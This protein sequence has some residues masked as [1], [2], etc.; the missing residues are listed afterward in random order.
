[1]P[2][3]A[4]PAASISAPKATAPRPHHDGVVPPS[5]VA[6]A[7]TGIDVPEGT[8]VVVVDFACAAGVDLLLDDEGLAFP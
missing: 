5:P 3:T 4:E 8:V 1:M 7:P 6:G 2:S